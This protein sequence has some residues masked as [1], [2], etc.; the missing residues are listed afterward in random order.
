MAKYLLDTGIILGYIR[1]SDYAKYAEQ[2]FQLMAPANISVMSIVS[3]GEIYSLSTQ[4]HWGGKKKKSLEMVLNEIH[5]VDISSPQV[6]KRYAKIDAYSQ[7]KLAGKKL[8]DGM[9]SSRNM[10]KNDLWIAATASVLNARLI[11]TDKDFVHLDNTFL[12]M[13]YIDPAINYGS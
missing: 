10:G 12:E 8:P 13:V 2:K 3:V 9:E 1:A 6:L 11:T 4:F 5:Q 7:G